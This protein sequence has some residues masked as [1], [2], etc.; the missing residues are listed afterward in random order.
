MLRY[1][2]PT[3]PTRSVPRR[4]KSAPPRERSI[5]GEFVRRSA[6][7]VCC[8]A[9]SVRRCALSA[10]FCCALAAICSGFASI[11]AGTHEPRFRYIATNSCSGLQFR[12]SMR[13]PPIPKGAVRQP[14]PRPQQSVESGR[15]AWHGASRAFARCDR[16]WPLRAASEDA[17]ILRRSRDDHL[18]RHRLLR[19]VRR[20]IRRNVSRSSHRRLCACSGH[21]ARAGAT[22]RHPGLGTL[23]VVTPVAPRLRVT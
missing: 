2:P 16:L 1:L 22:G 4:H 19:S 23:N 17:I 6:L 9:L 11:G 10:S 20:H 18:G 3:P 12:P 8:S 15:L 7:S 13:A 14:C 21:R 5:C